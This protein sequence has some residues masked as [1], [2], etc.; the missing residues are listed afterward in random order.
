MFLLGIF[1]VQKTLYFYL[2][3]IMRFY[4]DVVIVNWLYPERTT[5]ILQLA[6]I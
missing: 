5:G 6:V 3:I 2:V 4:L 1:P